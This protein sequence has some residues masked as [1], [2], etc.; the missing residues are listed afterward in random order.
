MPT[1]TKKS[2]CRFCHAYCA[3]EV[4]VADN[5]VVAVRGDRSNPVYGGYT[6]I[7]G[8]QMPEQHNH[9]ERLRS[10]RKRQPDGSFVAISSARALDEIAEI[11]TRIIATHGP[12]AIAS[13]N[14]TYAFQNS[15]ALA[16]A[17][18]WHQGIGSP[19]YYTSVTIDQP[20]KFI[21][22]SRHGVWAGGNHGFEAADVVMIIGN[23]AVVS[24][25][26]P[27]GGLPPFNPAKRLRDAKRR[28]LK[29]ICVDPRRTE[30]ARDADLHLQIRPGEDPTLLA[31][32]LR[33]IFEEGLHDR[34]FC[35]AHV[36]GVDALR[37][38]V[39]PF[40]PDY[41][42]RR[43]HVP[44]QQ[45]ITAAR[46][47]AR[48]PRGCATAGTGPDM[49]PHPN[50]TEH[51]VLS[52]NT[53]CGR[54][55]REGDLVPNPGIL[56]AVTPRRAQAISPVPAWGSGPRSR[57]RGLGQVFGE[58]PSAALNDEILEPGE[59][60]IRALISVGGNP[61]VAWPDQLKTLRAM[62]ALELNVSIDIKMSAT[63]KLAHYVIAPKL[64]LER[65]DAT[66]L[67]D[68][69][70]EQ[71]YAHYTEP[72][73]E[74]GFDVIEEWEF[75]WGMAHRMRTP[76]NLPGGPLDLDVKPTKFEV[77]EKVTAGARVPLAEV[78]RYPGGHVFDDV[79]V[80]VEPP[81]PTKAGRL[82]LAPEGIVEELRA[83]R[84]E[85]V[86]AD[87]GY[88]VRGG[89]FSHRLI[90]RRLRHVYNSSARDLSLSRAKGTT[91]PAYMNAADLTALGL[92]SGDLV[93]ISSDHAAI[94]AV[95][96]ATD[97]V[98]SGVV[99][100]AHAWGDTPE[101]DGQVREIGSTTNRLVSNE[102]DYDPIT[103]MA[104]QSAIPV[105]VR[106]VTEGPRPR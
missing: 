40:T 58:M 5:R 9:P 55:N 61:V 67:T 78:R 33:V 3:I 94:L 64:S 93:E 27:F 31:G 45:M 24:M 97:E 63:A 102:R 21:A 66:V 68:S 59:G 19:S 42:E 69:W 77:L 100:M 15:A 20:A 18:A 30:V 89:A 106:S 72:V 86:A 92:A 90:S 96:E 80:V 53:V 91:N 49:A 47:F 52:L 105:N 23:N 76:I 95:A 85:P 25:Y 75:F 43:T 46:L 6:C 79:R 50:L 17:R 57:V 56:T 48:G 44:A 81:D 35:A 2:Y 104:R 54:Y 39:G 4:D 74:P 16:V 83:V 12:R 88:G 14:G 7:K 82:Q 26:S 98:P 41:V 62:E 70:Y 10:S 1:Q 84:A 71:P 101:H 60:Q 103:G 8:R 11:L 34:T 87:G 28:G 73:I 37:D 36:D 65:A 22:P 29:V 99:S 38:A 32:M 51:L 13:Y